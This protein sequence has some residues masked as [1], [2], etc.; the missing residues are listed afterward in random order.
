LFLVMAA[1]VLVACGDKE[2]EMTTEELKQ[3]IKESEEELKETYRS[4]NKKS[5]NDNDEE[6]T[7]AVEEQSNSYNE[8]DDTYIILG[9][10]TLN[11]NKEMN[12][13]HGNL[14]VELQS[15]EVDGDE[16]SL[17]FWWNHWASN[18]DI[19]FSY[20]AYPSV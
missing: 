10:D 17:G 2:E 4:M 3:S 20:F 13:G 12:F 6:V 15:V 1:L 19:H 8:D 14:N 9:N 16:L 7:E 18:E 11:V 5:E